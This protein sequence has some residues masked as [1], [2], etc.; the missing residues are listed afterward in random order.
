M[1]VRPPSALRGTFLSGFN[2]A[3]SLERQSI[4][5]DWFVLAGLDAATT[6]FHN[7]LARE[8]ERER[9]R[10][11]RSQFYSSMK[12]LI[13]AYLPLECC[14]R[15]RAADNFLP[16]SISRTVLLKFP[17]EWS[18]SPFRFSFSSPCHL[19]IPHARQLQTARS[20]RAPSEV[21]SAD[22]HTDSTS[23]R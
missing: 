5:A 7:N 19:A 8:R 12:T 13:A 20:E 9:E 10:A 3:R 16:S 4:I 14:L 11:E 23:E 15:C 2:Q 22:P 6:E 1:L 17:P 21:Q 18:N